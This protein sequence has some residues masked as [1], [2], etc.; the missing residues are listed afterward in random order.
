MALLHGVELGRGRGLHEHR[1][2]FLLDGGKAQGSIRAHSREDHADALGSL[3]GGQGAQEEINGQTQPTRRCRSQQVQHSVQ[4]R[5]IL[6]GWNDIDAIRLD[7][8]AILDL[9]NLHRR[10][11]G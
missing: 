3:V 10:S 6:V 7:L 1:A 9:N 5:Q 2:A 8:Q 11:P 4:D